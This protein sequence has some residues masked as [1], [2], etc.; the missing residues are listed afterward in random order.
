MPKSF[1]KTLLV[2]YPR[3]YQMNYLIWALVKQKLNYW[4]KFTV[5]MKSCKEK[6]NMA[7]ILLF[8]NLIQTH[9]KIIMGSVPDCH[10]KGESHEFFGIPLHIIFT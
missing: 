4:N 5:Q 7:N 6:P 2:T 3:T 9:A 1:E 8:G 10:N